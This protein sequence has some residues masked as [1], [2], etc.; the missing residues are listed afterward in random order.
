VRASLAKLSPTT[1]SVLVALAGAIVLAAGLFLLVMPQRHKA[2]QLKEDIAT[3]Q[4]QIT[5]ARAL[6]RQKP[7]QQIRVADVFKVTKAMPDDADMTGV[8]LQLQQTASEAGVEF[9]SITP[10]TSETGTGYTV[11][12]ID[13]SFD[14]NYYSLNDFLFRLRK[15]VDVHRGVLDAHGR[16]FSV[17]SITFGAGTDGY[18]AL[19]AHLRVNAYVYNPAVTTPVPVTSTGTTGTTETTPPSDAVASGATS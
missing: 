18:P 15:L 3:T 8:I 16:L 2:A 5:V 1:A 9:D 10:S 19:T 13:L 14:G 12:P 11:Q 4:S 17:A 6:A 7:E